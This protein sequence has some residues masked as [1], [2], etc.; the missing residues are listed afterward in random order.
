MVVA[1]DNVLQ[2]KMPSI[3]YVLNFLSTEGWSN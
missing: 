3:A 1:V 2:A